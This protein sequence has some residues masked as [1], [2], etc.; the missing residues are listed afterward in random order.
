MRFQHTTW[1]RRR[2]VTGKQHRIL[3]EIAEIVDVAFT[4]VEERAKSWRE[5]IVEQALLEDAS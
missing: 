5:E 4:I 2:R 1:G 3:A